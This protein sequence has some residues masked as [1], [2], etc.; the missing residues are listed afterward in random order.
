MKYLKISSLLVLSLLL[1]VPAALADV[2][3]E[4]LQAFPVI[5]AESLIEMLGPELRDS[6]RVGSRRM[7]PAATGDD[8]PLTACPRRHSISSC[9]SRLPWPTTMIIPCLQLPVALDRR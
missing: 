2:T 7:I 9:D 1:F 5:R 3:C 6:L 8:L 4:V